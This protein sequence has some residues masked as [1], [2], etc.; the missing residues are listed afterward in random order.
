MAEEEQGESP[1][2]QTFQKCLSQ[3]EGCQGE[4]VH[5]GHLQQVIHV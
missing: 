5:Q 4:D 2:K 3:A 1:S